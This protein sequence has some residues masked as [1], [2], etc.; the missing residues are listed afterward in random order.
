MQKILDHLRSPKGLVAIASIIVAVWVVVVGTP[1]PAAMEEVIE[2]ATS[3]EIEAA[4]DG[5]ISV[6]PALEGSAEEGPS[7]GSAE[8]ETED[9]AEGSSK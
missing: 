3:T 4:E 7:E 8:P 2:A 6:E 9:P 1:P 5:T